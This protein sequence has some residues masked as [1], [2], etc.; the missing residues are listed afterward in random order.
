MGEVSAQ[1]VLEELNPHLGWTYVQWQ[2]NFGKG[3]E[4]LGEDVSVKCAETSQRYLSRE[5]AIE[6]AKHRIMI[7]IREECGDYPEDKVHWVAS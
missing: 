4:A 6:E 1:I 5:E 3:E 7:R 2:I